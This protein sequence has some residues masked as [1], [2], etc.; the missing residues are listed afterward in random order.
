MHADVAGRLQRD[1]LVVGR[2]VVEGEPLAE[3]DVEGP[4]L[5]LATLEAARANLAERLKGVAEELESTEET[6]RREQAAAQAAVDEARATL[7]TYQSS[8]RLAADAATRTARL[9]QL[10]LIPEIASVQAATEAE[11]T[12]GAA[13]RSPSPS[14]AWS[15]SGRRRPPGT[16]LRS[17]GSGASSRRSRARRMAP[18]SSSGAR[19]TRW[20]GGPFE[21]RSRAAWASEPTFAPACT[22][23]G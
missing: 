1:E 12:A 3:L 5:A 4:R 6:T 20:T 19:H 9:H 10:G 23:R 15:A 13:R 17:S 8:A 14:S 18:Q 22:S 7:Q 2:E 21:R 16:P 11:R